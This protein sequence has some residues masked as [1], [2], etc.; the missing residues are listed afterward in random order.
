MPWDF[1]V[2]FV[3]LGVLLPWRGRARLKKLLEQPQLSGSER[4]ALY[5]STIA[6]QWLMALIAAWR[7]WAHGLRLP[8]LGWAYTSN[9]GILLP[10][11]IGAVTFGGI[12]WLNLRRLGR[13]KRP[14]PGSMR[15]LAERILPQSGN[16]LTVYLLLALTAGLCEEFLYR[17]FA[18][19]VFTRAGL[20]GWAAVLAS[21]VLFGLA[22]LYQGTGGL[23]STTIIGTVFGAARIAY[24]SLIPVMAWHAAFDAAAGLAGRRYL[25]GAQA[26]S[27]AQEASRS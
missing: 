24:H 8:D 19:A 9:V 4:M 1:C 23:V 18:I 26:P 11:A 20:P 7:A 3:V 12:Q 25:L 15:R 21:S 22:H 6:F 13:T 10:A 14:A 16:E 5:A 17:G 2:I 27:P